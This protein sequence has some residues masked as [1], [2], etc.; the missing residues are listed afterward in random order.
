MTQPD[1]I[2]AARRELLERFRRGELQTPK[3]AL[4]PLIARPS[5]ELA[6]LAPGLEQLWFH[7][8]LSGGAPINNES[9][10][11]HKRGPLDTAVLE[12]CFNEIARRHEIWRSAFPT[13]DGK[14]VQRVDPNVRVPLPHIDL[15]HL[16]VEKREAE[17]LRIGTDDARR[18]FDLNVAPLF[19]VRLVR[20]ADDYHRIYLTVHRLVF[21]CVSVERVLIR[22]LAALY[23]AYSLGQPSPLPELV[24]QYGD[25]AT[26]KQRQIT[27]GS[28]AQMEYW[29]QNLSGDLPPCGLPSDRPRSPELARRS[30]METCTIPAPLTE[31]IRALGQREGVTPFMILLAAFQVLLHR[32][33][34][35]DEIVVGGKTNARTRPEFE[36]LLGSFVETVVFRSL[37]SAELSFREFLGRVKTTVLGALAHSEISFDEI[38]RELA[39]K[40]DNSRHPLFQVL[41]STR[42]P[43][44]DFPNGWDLTDMEVHSGA[45]SFELFVEFA[46]FPH[47]LAGRFVYSTDLFDRATILRLQGNFL[48][49]LEELVADP[50]QAV[51]R[52]PLLT[53]Q[54][55]QTLLVDWNNTGKSFPNMLVHE[56]FEAQAEANPDRIALV[57]RGQQLTYAELNA[58]ANKLAHYLRQ[59]G[60]ASGHLIGVYLERSFEMV[61]A[62]LSILKSGAAYVPYD[63]ELPVFRLNMMLEDSRPVFVLTQQKFK[64]NLADYAG[65]TLILDSH[66]EL[67]EGQPPSNPGSAVQPADAIYA[68][69]T[70]GS[71][72]V[73]KA[74]VNT[75]EAVANRI[76]WMQDQYPLEAGDRILQKT[77]HSFD[78]SVWEFFWAISYGATLVI[79]E[80]GGHKDPAYVAALIGAERITTIHF[81]PS[82][83]REFLDAG[84]LDRCGSLKRVFASGEELPPDL[85]QKFYQRLGAQLH[86]LYGPTEAAVDVT[87][88]DCGRPS[89]CASVPIGR[90]ISNVKMY[91]LDRHLA[92][93][94]IGVAGELHIGGIAVA[95]GYL[96]RDELTAERF[97]SDPFDSR[98]GQ[99]LYKTGDRAR[100]LADGNIE[101]LGRLDNQIKLRGFRI[102]LGDIEATLLQ[103]CGVRAAAVVL[104]EY[105]DGQRL[106]AYVVPNHAELDTPSLRLYLRERLPE[107][108]IP[109]AFVALESLPKTSSGKLDRKAALAPAVATAPQREFVPPQDEIEERLV[110]LWQEMLAVNRISVTDNYFD[111]GGHSLLALRLF[112]EIKFSFQL[113][114]PLATLFYAP[115]VRTMAGV[116]RDS[117][118]QA[119]APVV[120][121]QPNGTKPPIF[122]IG[123]LN[124]EVILFRRLA[125]ELGP[126]QPIFGLQPFSMVDRLS[127]VETLAASYIEQ[128]RQWGEPRPFCLLGYSFGGLVA[129]E[130]A[131]QLA[132]AGAEPP[133]VALIDSAYL[134]GCKSLESWSE[135]MRR[136]RYH[137]NHI[138]Y[139]AAGLRHLLNRLRSR[140]FRTIHRVSTRLGVGVPRIASDIS[141]RQLLAAESYRAKPYAGRVCLFKA[142]S[143]PEFFGADPDL[144]WGG[145]LSELQIEEVP[146]DHGTINTGVNLKVLSRK[147]KAALST[148]RLAV[149]V[150][151]RGARVQPILS[152]RQSRSGQQQP[153]H[154][155]FGRWR[156]KKAVYVGSVG[157]EPNQVPGVVDAIDGRSGYAK[158]RGGR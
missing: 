76:F 50:C 70:S 115:T 158:S 106:V 31:A 55:R 49:L 130:M 157:I 90:P 152:D 5:G 88:W 141:G 89:P 155:R 112:S 59:N 87:Y 110:N 80:P 137:L 148:V 71:T 60:A 63:T 3:R 47:S 147:L 94:P 138:V 52:V 79:A 139:G 34:G 153:Y 66:C 11:I 51:S 6:P 136:Y 37:I 17:A 69:Y 56:M 123:A 131:Y 85:R 46:E 75:H 15:S 126:D 8:Q 35:E 39:P 93:V 33:S 61:V 111:L 117:G 27:G 36:P 24:F 10:T 2:S 42:A 21:D 118:V 128:L 127:T 23:N 19:R 92:P 44:G 150:A 105:A 119:A 40:R 146:G 133:L 77:P 78:V 129:V 7:D 83:L 12:R 64:Q 143:R 1:T 54:E 73:P 96:N 97:I 124:G 53:G 13:I 154:A 65:H 102:E 68:I 29:R 104:R 58:R 101:Y 140:Y 135:R 108:M 156:G 99:R 62:L 100:F 121:I 38:V 22:E 122:C 151:S 57:F 72:G 32:Y 48:V 20:C 84:N 14:V 125:L 98:P 132:K 107:H 43:F 116:I 142:E 81:V 41:F 86:N 113:E 95:R 45:S 25:Y 103:N 134:Q 114:L 26:W 67:L 120:P 74:A 9:F 149:R 28:H 145:L 30:G 4:E 18:P 109:S 144:G 16:P 82:M 91:V